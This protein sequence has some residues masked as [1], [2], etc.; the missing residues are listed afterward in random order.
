VQA[1]E[2]RSLV[3]GDA[4]ATLLD[5]CVDAYLVTKAPN[6]ISAT[7]RQPRT[8]RASGAPLLR[9][10]QIGPIRVAPLD[11]SGAEAPDGEVGE[12]GERGPLVTAGVIG[13]PD[14]TWARRS[15]RWGCFARANTPTPPS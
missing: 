4:V 8:G 2:S 3:R 6:A 10:V 14:N 15:M 13:V 7:P 1:L 9:G 12:V 5:S 11:A